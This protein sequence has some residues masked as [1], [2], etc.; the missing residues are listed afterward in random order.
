M[1]K[2][3]NKWMLDQCN[4]DNDMCFFK[5]EK[6]KSLTA[7]PYMSSREGTAERH[8]LTMKRGSARLTAASHL[9]GREDRLPLP[10]VEFPP[11]CEQ[12]HVARASRSLP[13]LP[14]ESAL[15]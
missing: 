12:G 5:E 8:G 7:S 1:G 14:E 6:E 2:L 3:G 10:A 15:V 4:C 11:A 13:E 9:T